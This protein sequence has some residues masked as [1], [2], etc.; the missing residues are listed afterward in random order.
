MAKH[1]AQFKERH[2]VESSYKKTRKTGFTSVAESR[3]SYG[4]FE[5]VVQSSAKSD[6]KADVRRNQVF[7]S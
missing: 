5:F 4:H 1:S 3:I 7:G 6:V 2:I